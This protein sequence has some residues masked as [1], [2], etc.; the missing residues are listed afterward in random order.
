MANLPEWKTIRGRKQ[1]FYYQLTGGGL[2]AFAGLWDRWGGLETSALITTQANDLV[3]QVHPRMPV[4]LD[5]EAFGLWLDE[6]A[7]REE[8][9]GLLAPFPADAMQAYPVSPRVNK[10]GVD[11]PEL[12]EPI[13]SAINR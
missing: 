13:E 2:F 8:L 9:L 6:G 10:G 11:G 3:R 12:I 7:D 4:I 1:P 5:P